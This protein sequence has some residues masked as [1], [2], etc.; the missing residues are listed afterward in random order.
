MFF[1]HLS[2][3][4]AKCSRGSNGTLFNFHVKLIFPAISLIDEEAEYE[5]GIPQSIDALVNSLRFPALSITLLNFD[6][7]KGS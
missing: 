2:W 1:S 4:Q 5:Q 6:L 7:L 3:W